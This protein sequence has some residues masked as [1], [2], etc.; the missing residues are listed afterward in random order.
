VA[1]KVRRHSN[2]KEK[3]KSPGPPFWTCF[4]CDFN[5]KT[6]LALNC[7]WRMLVAVLS[8]VLK[9]GEANWLT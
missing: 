2:K 9:F 1:P 6:N 5:Q 4:K 8:Y 7:I 3:G